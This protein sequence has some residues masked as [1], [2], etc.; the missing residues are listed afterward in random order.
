MSSRHLTLEKYL[1]AL[2]TKYL[3]IG[4]KILYLRFRNASNMFTR[5]I[6]HGTC[7]YYMFCCRGVQNP[8]KKNKSGLKPITQ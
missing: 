1:A 8:T 7:K 5:Q 6:L 2:Y 3:E 4:K